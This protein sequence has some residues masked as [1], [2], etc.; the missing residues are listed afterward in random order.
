MARREAARAIGR[1]TLT[2]KNQMTIPLAIRER[3]NLMPG[4]SLI[5][6]ESETGAIY[7]RKAARLDVAL[8]SSLENTLSE[9]NSENDEQAYRNL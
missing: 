7:I 3:L 1:V 6:E 5:F 8:L 9:W 2:S 4:D